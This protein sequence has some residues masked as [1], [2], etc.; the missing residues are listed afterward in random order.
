[1]QMHLLV[2]PPHRT[3]AKVGAAA[4][5]HGGRHHRRADLPLRTR[6]S[7]RPLP[8]R[9]SHPQPQRGGPQ[10]HRTSAGSLP[11]GLTPVAR[12]SQAVS[13]LPS[14]ARTPR[15]YPPSCSAPLCDGRLLAYIPFLGSG[16]HAAA[17]RASLSACVCTRI[18]I[19]ILLFLVILW[20]PIAR[21]ISSST[22]PHTGRVRTPH[23]RAPLALVLLDTPPST[24]RTAARVPRRPSPSGATSPARTPP[25]NLS[26]SHPSPVLHRAP[27]AASPSCLRRPQASRVE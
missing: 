8:H 14:L 18:R 27:W 7:V 22:T 20:R 16:P 25:R 5:H 11:L 15:P 3:F 10:A 1:M 23:S 17:T 12:S 13:V 24:Q 6:S 9:R 4:Y 2:D 26:P 21:P 19:G